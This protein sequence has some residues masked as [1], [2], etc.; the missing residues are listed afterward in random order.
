MRFLS[1]EELDQEYVRVK[2]K[3]LAAMTSS[4]RATK[5]Q[6]FRG[7]AISLSN[8]APITISMTFHFQFCLVWKEVHL[9]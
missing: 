5:I 9:L 8:E 2:L 1:C 7:G 6:T 3:S 4:G